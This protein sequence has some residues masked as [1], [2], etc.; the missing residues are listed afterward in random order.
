VSELATRVASGVVMA[1]IGLWCLW[2]GGYAFLV[3][4]SACGCLMLAE[5]TGLA[6][7]IGW[8]RTGQFAGVLY[9]LPP[10]AALL[11]L[12]RADHGLGLT[13]WTL[14]IVW[15]TDICAYFAGRA[16][17]GPKIAPAI[18]PSK[19][20]AGL[21]GGMLGAGLTGAF[22]AHRLSLPEALFWLGAP[23]AM[24]A[25]VGDFFE[26]WMKRRAGVKDSGSIIPGHGGVMDRLDGLVPVTTAVGVL[27]M[28]GFL[29]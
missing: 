2:M 9:T 16:I 6:R 15:A 18:S 24:L 26:S 11:F 29:A 27:F 20:W 10:T 1:A 7:R 22:L 25:Q 23:L 28:G 5:W 12:R 4:V 8:G 14:M 3:L 17:G 13:L 19:T 21:C